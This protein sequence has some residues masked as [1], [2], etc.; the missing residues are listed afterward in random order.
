MKELKFHP[1]YWKLHKKFYNE[2][3][4][5][6]DIDIADKVMRE[7]FCEEARN[8]DHKVNIKIKKSL[9]TRA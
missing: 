6:L 8:L 7:P 4:N 2:E 5:K 3:L 9:L 1:A